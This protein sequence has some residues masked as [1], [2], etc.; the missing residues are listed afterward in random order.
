MLGKRCTLGRPKKG[1]EESI[2]ID[3]KEMGFQD[4]RWIELD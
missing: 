1:W 3:L 2:K 4:R